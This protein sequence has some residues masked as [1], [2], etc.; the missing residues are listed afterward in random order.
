MAISNALKFNKS[1]KELGNTGL[2]D[3]SNNDLRCEGATPICDSLKINN[4]LA[5]LGTS[6]KRDD[7]KLPRR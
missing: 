1:L 3:L 6:L 7:W 2:F 5:S 4:T